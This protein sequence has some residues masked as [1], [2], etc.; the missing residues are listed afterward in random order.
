MPSGT[1]EAGVV[2]LAEDEKIYY[3][4]YALMT[5]YGLPIGNANRWRE[6]ETINMQ[7]IGKVNK[8]IVSNMWVQVI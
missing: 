4:Y 8:Q 6:E 5:L 3:L 1:G 2:G 7:I